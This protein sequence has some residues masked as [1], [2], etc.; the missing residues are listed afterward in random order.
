MRCDAIHTKKGPAVVNS[1]KFDF[2]KILGAW[3]V[4]LFV[5]AVIMLVLTA[6]EGRSLMGMVQP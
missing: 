3:L 6:G 5:Q 1:E 2:L 4:V